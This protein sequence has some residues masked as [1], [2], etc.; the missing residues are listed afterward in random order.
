M[1]GLYS[2]YFWGTKAYLREANCPYEHI[3]KM[4]FD[5]LM[6]LLWICFI[7]TYFS[8]FGL[9]PSSFSE[10]MRHNPAW[11][12]WC[13]M[14][15][16]WAV[17]WVDDLCWIHLFFLYHRPYLC[18]SSRR[19]LKAV[20]GRT[21]TTTR[22][23]PMAPASPTSHSALLQTLPGRSTPHVNREALLLI[24]AASAVLLAPPQILI[25]WPQRPHMST[26]TQ[27]S[28]IWAAFAS[29]IW[30][31]QKLWER[32]V[33]PCLYFCDPALLTEVKKACL[34]IST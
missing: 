5:M 33:I 22:Q 11:G 13:P 26:S 10:C 20:L 6:R 17:S 1:V 8:I 21:P 34:R 29:W 12:I 30:W 16:S 3:F 31:V 24:G 2:S 15:S 4:C 9:H 19:I 28:W 7:K 32:W 25:Q 23:R 27:L 14:I 18:K